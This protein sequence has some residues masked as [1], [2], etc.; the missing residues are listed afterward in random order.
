MK[1]KKSEKNET[2]DPK[3]KKYKRKIEN[4]EKQKARYVYDNKGYVY[5]IYCIVN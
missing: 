4:P 2:K 3:P 1:R 5:N